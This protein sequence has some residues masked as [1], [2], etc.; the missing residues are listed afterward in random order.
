[1]DVIE[2]NASSAG[3]NAGRPAGYP[4]DKW[5]QDGKKIRIWHGED[6]KVEPSSLRP[7]IHQTARR[8]GG[9]ASTSISRK[10]GKVYI[11]IVYTAAKQL[12]EAD[13]DFDN[14]PTA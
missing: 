7:Q 12:T 5:L 10:D 4:W 3:N 8:R 6:F 14:L 9:R 2:E 13:F 11:D 1:M